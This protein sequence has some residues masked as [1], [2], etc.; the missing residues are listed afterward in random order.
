M[1]NNFEVVLGI[2]TEV[3]IPITEA[4]ISN[5]VSVLQTGENVEFSLIEVVYVDEDK[6]VEINTKH[7]DKTYVTDII[8]FDYTEE[9]EAI[10]GTLYCCA[11]RITEQASEFNEPLE[12][13]FHRIL[14]HGMLHLCGYDDSSDEAKTLMTQKEDFY[15]QQLNLA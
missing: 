13:E 11:S 7:L 1:K 3:E 6:I 8:T 5:C 14:I 15:L 4:S 9:D 12:K 2:E 10:E